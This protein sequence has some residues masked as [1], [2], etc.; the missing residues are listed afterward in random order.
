M[1]AT[2]VGGGSGLSSLN[3]LTS[4]EQYF[5]VGTTGSIFNVSSSGST[6]TFNIPIA[7][8]G[9]TGLVSTS[10]QSFAGAKTFTNDVIISSS[11]ASTF[12]RN[13]SLQVYGGVG[14]SGQLSFNQA[15]MGFTGILTN[16]SLA[17]IGTTGSPITLS[18]LTDNSLLFEGTSGQLFSI[19]N[20]L[21]T[22]EI[23][24]VSDISG[25]PI[26][27][28]Y[29]N[30]NVTVGEFGGNLGIGLSNPFYKLHVI[31]SVGFTSSTA[32]TSTSTGTL[33][34]S[35]G[36]GIGQSVSIGGRLQLFNSSNYTAFVSSASGNTVYTLPA[37]TPATGSSV[38]QS[39]S[40]G[41]M[42]WVPMTASGSGT[43]IS[44]LNTLT[45]G[46][47]Y[48]S[49]GTS[50]SIFNISSSGSTHT[51]NIPIAGS[52]STGLISTSS[53]TIAGQ[54]TFTS[55]IIGDLTGTAT[56]SG[57]AST[58]SYANQ[59][60]YAITSGSSSTA[61]TAT[62]SHQSGYAITSGSSAFASTA[63]YS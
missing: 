33:V 48:F 29:A 35:G 26:I 27:S 34:V 31:G 13:G 20:N 43:G 56:T 21:I 17:F 30:Q 53:Q 1:T 45:D 49:T 18:V 9:A 54:K 4:G 23:F 51:F 19:D 25:L 15:S 63:S 22:G 39:T 11:T 7:G 44:T 37:T 47:Q 62:Y 55:A 5:A 36:V 6:H 42:S 59:S 24:S 16:P 58:A 41:V 3:L 12:M 28:A 40:A 61:N 14:I 38:L 2:G 60:G 50:G 8:T 52:A 46:I 32:S 57:F 10:T